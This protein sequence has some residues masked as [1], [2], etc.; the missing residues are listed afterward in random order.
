MQRNLEGQTALDV[1]GG[2]ACAEPLLVAH[3][4]NG[5]REVTDQGGAVSDEAHR[6]ASSLLLA[7][8]LRK[9]G[10]GEDN[11]E[12]RREEKGLSRR[13]T[14]FLL[15][16][17]TPFLEIHRKTKGML[18]RPR[19]QDMVERAEEWDIE[20]TEG[21]KMESLWRRMAAFVLNDK[22]R[23]KSNER[24]EKKEGREGSWKR[25]RRR[26]RQNRTSNRRCWRMCWVRGCQ[27]MK[28]EC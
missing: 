8:L 23:H 19:Q 9:A 22:T 4:G 18:R 25:K 27:K 15:H 17:R 13:M 11:E 16:E 24:K 3:G 12:E 14:A 7:H 2:G 21:R 5:A 28:E 1:C 20:E 10:K 26:R 6:L